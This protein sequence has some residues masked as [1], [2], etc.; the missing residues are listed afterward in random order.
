MKNQ[1]DKQY[2]M[3]K[4]KRQI[5]REPGLIIQGKCCCI[6][7]SQFAFMEVVVLVYLLRNNVDVLKAILESGFKLLAR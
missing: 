7:L 3:A 6:R 2:A 1:V 5:L 4:G